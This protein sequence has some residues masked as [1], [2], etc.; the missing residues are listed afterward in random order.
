MYVNS[1][2]ILLVPPGP[3]TA[4]AADPK[5]PVGVTPVMVVSLTTVKLPI[6]DPPIVAPVAFVNPVPPI[7]IN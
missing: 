6:V 4:T 5:L 1:P 7:V 2:L 3:V